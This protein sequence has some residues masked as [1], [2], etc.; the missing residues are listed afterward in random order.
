MVAVGEEIPRQQRKG[1]E[2]LPALLNDLQQTP[3]EQGSQGGSSGDRDIE[4][5][6]K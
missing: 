4:V 5:L 6:G 2:C 1:I 3:K